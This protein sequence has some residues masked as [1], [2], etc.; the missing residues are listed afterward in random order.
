ME[1]TITLIVGLPASGSHDSDPW[2]PEKEGAGDVGPGE[3]AGVGWKVGAGETAGVDWKVGSGVGN[4]VGV[5][6]G[7]G[8]GEGAGGAAEGWIG[9]GE[10]AIG[11]GKPVGVEAT[12]GDTIEGL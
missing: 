12:V 8:S 11:A 6:A 7:T 4:T 9:A 2:P 3:T 5:G 1:I 10:G